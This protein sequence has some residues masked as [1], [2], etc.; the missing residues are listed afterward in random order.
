MRIAFR[1]IAGRKGSRHTPHPGTHAVAVD[2]A[3][4]PADECRNRVRRLFES[5]L[6]SSVSEATPSRQTVHIVLHVTVA[7]METIRVQLHALFPDAIIR[8]IHPRGSDRRHDE[9]TS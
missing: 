4:L 2:L 1:A 7:K 5:P 3:H 6:G 8:D 9:E